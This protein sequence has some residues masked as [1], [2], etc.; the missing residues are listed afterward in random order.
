MN[1]R[2]FLKGL[3]GVLAAGVAPAFIGSDVL[4][5]VKKIWTGPLTVYTIEDLRRL[6]PPPKCKVIVRG[7]YRPGDGGGGTYS[8]SP[9]IYS[10]NGGTIIAAPRGTYE[11]KVSGPVDVRI[12]GA[13]PRL[14]DNTD[15]FRRAIA[16]CGV[17]LVPP[18]TYQV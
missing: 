18:G 16:A 17:V 1:R 8:W 12:F 6:C 4:M 14:D 9:E 7:Y 15:A 5:P 3:G 2:D 10:D 13:Q 11:A